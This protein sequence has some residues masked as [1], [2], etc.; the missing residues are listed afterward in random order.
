MRH[1]CFCSSEV[2][3]RYA[4]RRNDEATQEQTARHSQILG[5]QMVQVQ[6]YSRLE[7][8][9]TICV[10][11][12]LPVNHG[13]VHQIQSRKSPSLFPEATQGTP[14]QHHQD[15]RGL[16]QRSRTPSCCRTEKV[17]K[18]EKKKKKLAAEGVKADQGPSKPKKRRL[19]KKEA[20]TPPATTEE[21]RAHAAVVEATAAASL[22]DSI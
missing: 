2:G 15:S 4:T 13:H 17:E 22:N 12:T 16:P 6:E 7:M 9:C 5:S 11:S 18:E 19:R 20:S 8:V 10:Q 14:L 1:S 3:L 21:E